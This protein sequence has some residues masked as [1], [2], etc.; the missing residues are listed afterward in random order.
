MSVQGPTDIHCLTPLRTATVLS[1]V[2]WLKMADPC[3]TAIGVKRSRFRDKVKQSA[4]ASTLRD[5]AFLVITL[6]FGRSH[7]I[8]KTLAEI[9]ACNDSGFATGFAGQSTTL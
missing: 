2:E 9:N 3:L 6:R 1:V 7:A 8:V 4:R 5:A